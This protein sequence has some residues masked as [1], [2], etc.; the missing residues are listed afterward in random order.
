MQKVIFL[1]L[2]IIWSHIASANQTEKI[3]IKQ[4]SNDTHISSGDGIVV[5]FLFSEFERTIVKLQNK[6]NPDITI[7]WHLQNVGDENIVKMPAGEYFISEIVAGKEDIAPLAKMGAN[8]GYR[9]ASG[10]HLTFY[11]QKD[12]NENDPKAPLFKVEKNR[13]NYI[14]HLRILDER[15]IVVKD[16]ESSNI[17]IAKSRLPNIF[18]KYKY[19]KNV[20]A[21]HW[22]PIDHNDKE[23]F[24]SVL[25]DD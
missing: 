7:N 1:F 13:I 8:I 14:G 23:Y 3:S 6:N 4:I 2:V 21:T 18:N 25:G 11:Y 17:E 15:E 24:E 5:V 20:K 12:P 22:E 10:R 19:V 16:T 9:W